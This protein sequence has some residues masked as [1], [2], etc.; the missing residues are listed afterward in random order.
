MSDN[1]NGP[2]RIPKSFKPASWRGTLPVEPQTREIGVSFNPAT[3]DVIRLRLCEEDAQNL[4]ETIV[5]YYRLAGGWNSQSPKPD[6]ERTVNLEF[7]LNPDA[8]QTID[9]L[10]INLEKIASVNK[11]NADLISE[12]IQRSLEVVKTP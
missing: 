5:E 12:F 9:Q 1:H 4:V 11:E 2:S 10:T 3:G 8:Q 7:R 6:G